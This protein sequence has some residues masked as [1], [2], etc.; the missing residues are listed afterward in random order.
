MPSAQLDLEKCVTIQERDMNSVMEN[1]WAFTIC[2]AAVKQNP[3]AKRLVL[4]RFP[5]MGYIRHQPC[6]VERNP[7]LCRLAMQLKKS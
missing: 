6:V 2:L 5:T 7:S 4:G 3:S 1:A